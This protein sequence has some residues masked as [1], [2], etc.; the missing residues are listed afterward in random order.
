[1]LIPILTDEHLEGEQTYT[2]QLRKLDEDPLL[3][4]EGSLLVT[5]SNFVAITHSVFTMMSTSTSRPQKK[6]IIQS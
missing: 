4:E 3:K 6:I 2:L 1:M 5:E